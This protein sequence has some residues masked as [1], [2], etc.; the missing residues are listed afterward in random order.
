M[1]IPRHRQ[2]TIIRFGTATA[3]A[4]VMALGTA[5]CGSEDDAATDDATSE[6]TAT[7]TTPS[8]APTYPAFAP[9]SYTFRLEVLCYCPQVGAVRVTVKDGEVAE[10]KAISG[11]AK[12]TEAPEF[13]RLTINDIIERAN[14]PEADKVDVTWPTGQDYPSVV[15]VDQLAMATDDEVTYTI[16]NVRVQ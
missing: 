15:A 16:K 6:P 8:A 7:A 12:G 3:L 5:G 10:A 14:D 13:M 1:Q 9:A 4:A 2:R 11:E